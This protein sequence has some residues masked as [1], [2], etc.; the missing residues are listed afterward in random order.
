LLVLQCYKIELP[1]VDAQGY[2][3]RTPQQGH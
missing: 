3:E 2:P 1:D